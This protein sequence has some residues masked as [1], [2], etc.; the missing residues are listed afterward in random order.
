M[1]LQEKLIC[2]F[3][4]P[5]PDIPPSWKP[6]PKRVWSQSQTPSSNSNKENV[7]TAAMPHGKWK[8]SGLS[9]DEVCLHLLCRSCLNIIT[10]R[11]HT[12]RNATSL[13]TPLRFRLYVS[14]RS[15]EV[16]KYRSGVTF[17]LTGRQILFLDDRPNFIRSSSRHNSPN[18]SYR[19]SDRSCRFDRLPTF[20]HQSKETGT[21]YR[22]SAV[23]G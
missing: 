20:P 7:E 8:T 22:L 14:E 15:R 18:S 1:H 12:G 9:A 2:S 23:T 16:E 17:I 4:Y 21:I 13:C 19:P 10:A 6:D 5:L 3:R 11:S